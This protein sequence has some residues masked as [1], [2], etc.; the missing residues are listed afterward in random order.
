LGFELGKL[1]LEDLGTG[2]HSWSFREKREMCSALQSSRSLEKSPGPGL[3][4]DRGR[5][6]GKHVEGPREVS[7]ADGSLERWH[8]SVTP[9]ST[10]R[11]A[12]VGCGVPPAS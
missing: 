12:G 3:K 1:R 8:P 9:P 7:S 6:A 10:R 2:N 11:D 4:M 5:A